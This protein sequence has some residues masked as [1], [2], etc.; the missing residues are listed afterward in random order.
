MYLELVKHFS[1]R[2][3]FDDSNWAAYRASR[4]KHMLLRKRLSIRTLQAERTISKLMPGV[5][6]EQAI[7]PIELFF[8]V[9][10]WLRSISSLVGIGYGE[11]P[12]RVIICAAL[13]IF[14]YACLYALPNGPT[15]HQ[16]AASIYFSVVTFTTLGY[17]DIVPVGLFRFVAGTEALLGILLTGLFLF[18]LGRRTVSRV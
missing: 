16:F 5:A 18:C 8:A 10:A 17:G 15:A 4:L 11:K 9:T 3:M 6:D 7:G 14:L 2:G 13:S 1:S 12:G